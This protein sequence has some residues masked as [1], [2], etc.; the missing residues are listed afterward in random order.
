MPIPRKSAEERRA[1]ILEAA[2]PLIAERGFD[3]TPTLA[4]AQAAGISH[5]YLFRLFPAKED[6]NVAVVARCN[7][8]I[9]E[10]FAH[11]AEEARA[12]GEDPGPAMGAAYGE[13]LRER[14]TVLVQLH[15]HAASPTHPEIRE[16]MRASFA[17]LYG[18]VEQA[19]GAEPEAV[20]AFFAEGMLMNVAVALGLAELDAPWARA[21][22]PVKEVPADAPCAPPAGGPA[23]RSTAV[24]DAEDAPAP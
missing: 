19:S 21:L 14:D 15:A 16:A 23:P 3:G 11:A 7:G 22:A 17:D 1:E 8:I 12:R 9:R 18:V 13:L 6:L 2:M 24:P 20:R 10:R 5:A 4:I